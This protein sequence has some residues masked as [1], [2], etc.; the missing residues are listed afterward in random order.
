MDQLSKYLKTE[1][2]AG[3]MSGPFLR[4]QTERI[5][6]SPFQSLPFIVTIQPQGPGKPDKVH[7]C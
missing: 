4:E 2:L 3:R 7:V 5:L 1:V 6:C